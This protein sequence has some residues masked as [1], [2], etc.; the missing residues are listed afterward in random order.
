[1]NEVGGWERVD[2]GEGLEE[3]EEDGR[4]EKG[5]EESCLENVDEAE[6]CTKSILQDE[7]PDLRPTGPPTDD[8]HPLQF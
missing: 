7:I 2:E 4:L 6:S 5:Q 8:G 1:M 3:V